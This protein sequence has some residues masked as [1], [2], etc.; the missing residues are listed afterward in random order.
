[1]CPGLCTALRQRIADRK[2]PEQ[3][4]QEFVRAFRDPVEETDRVEWRWPPRPIRRDGER[5]GGR[6]GPLR[7]AGLP[8]PGSDGRSRS[9]SRGR[10]TSIGWPRIAA[11][12]SWI[13]SIPTGLH[14]VALPDSSSISGIRPRWAI[15]SLP[16]GRRTPSCVRAS[17]PRSLILRR[18]RALATRPAAGTVAAEAPKRSVFSVRRSVELGC[19]FAAGSLG[20]ES[21]ATPQALEHGMG[22][23]TRRVEGQ[24][25]ARVRLASRVVGHDAHDDAA[26]DL[27]PM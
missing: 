10:S 5:D 25:F 20:S 15:E 11:G 8:V 4:S 14:I 2:E 9:S 21:A 1:M 17:S 26:I 16:F 24:Q 12:Y 18:W 13:R 3:R 27:A 22:E 6:R 23:S 19:G 7:R